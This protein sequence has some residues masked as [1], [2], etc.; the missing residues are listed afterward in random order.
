MSALSRN[1]IVVLGEGPSGRKGDGDP[2]DEKAG[3]TGWVMGSLYIGEEKSCLGNAATVTPRSLCST[4]CRGGWRGPGLPHSP[5]PASLNS[6]R[7]TSST[8]DPA[9]PGSR[10]SGNNWRISS[11]FFWLQHAGVECKSLRMSKCRGA[12]FG[13]QSSR[14]KRRGELLLTGGRLSLAI[15]RL[16]GL[17]RLGAGSCW[18]KC[19]EKKKSPSTLLPVRAWDWL[20]R[21]S[22]STCHANGCQTHVPP[23]S[24]P[25]KKCHIPLL[26]QHQLLQVATPPTPK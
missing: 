24:R 13:S 3:R 10:G 23:K 17:S 18:K 2:E 6:R 11:P 1:L 15:L 9:V 5:Q 21:A 4:G 25:P 20:E 26:A 19:T 8:T 14:G 7:Q 16:L 22:I 12:W